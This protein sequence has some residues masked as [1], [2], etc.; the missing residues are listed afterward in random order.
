M[1]LFTKPQLQWLYFMQ[2]APTSA[3][4]FLNPSLFVTVVF[5]YDI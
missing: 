2:K 5:S 4:V 1:Y 3:G